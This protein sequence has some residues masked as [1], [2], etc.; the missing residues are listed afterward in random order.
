ME[1]YKIIGGKRVARAR[2]FNQKQYITD[3]QVY[4]AKIKARSVVLFMKTKMVS[5]LARVI[6][7]GSF[8]VIYFGRDTYSDIQSGKLRVPSFESLP[9]EFV[10]MVNEK[11]NVK[12]RRIKSKKPKLKNVEAVLEI[13][14][15]YTAAGK[16][17]KE[18]YQVVKLADK[19]EHAELIKKTVK[20][21]KKHAENGVEEGIDTAL[22]YTEKTFFKVCPKCGSKM[23]PNFI[24]LGPVG[25]MSVYQCGTCRFYLPRNID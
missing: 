8:C 7:R 12:K 4:D 5:I 22:D 23:K 25:R 16:E 17:R 2:I 6:D 10:E 24:V 3:F 14:S 19:V 21:K 11:E 1:K 13:Q 20:P 18:K 9:I 15:N